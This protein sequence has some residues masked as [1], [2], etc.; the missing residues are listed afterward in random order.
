[1]GGSPRVIGVSRQAYY[2]WRHRRDRGE[3]PEHLVLASELRAIWHESDGTYG[4]PRITH[5]LRRRGFCVNHKRVE[6][7]MRELE[8]AAGPRRRF[9]VTT[10]R[11]EDA[12]LPDL[13]RQD[14]APGEPKRRYVSDI[15]YVRTDEGFCY[16]A[17]VADLGSRR[18]VG[19][20]LGRH[21]PDDLV[22]EAIREA[23]GTR[24][25]LAG[26]IF[27]SDRGSQYLSRKV[28]SLL[29]T[30]GI[31]QSV[32]RVAT[33]Y[34][35]AV[36]ESFFGSLKRELVARYRFANLSGARSAIASWIHR[37]NTVR[38]HSSLGYLP[39]VEYEL[40]WACREVAVA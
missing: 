13:V 34:D 38:L 5:E 22:V 9:V 4:S 32:G 8:M 21:M 20:S 7:L 35:N 1:M 18:I 33:C 11:G 2:A 31:R 23:L 15:T 39:P 6:R 30:L 19:W 16:L 28:R 26:A 27:H 36:A 29:A 40:S 17:T 10:R 25:S 3:D 37:Y 12:A 24:G 14:F